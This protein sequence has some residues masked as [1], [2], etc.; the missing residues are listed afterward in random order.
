MNAHADLHFPRRD[1]EIRPASLRQRT[2]RKRD[3]ERIGALVGAARDPDDL[4][5]RQ[6]SVRGGAGGLEDEHIAG[7]AAPLRALGA[8]RR[9]DIVGRQHRARLDAFHSSS[10]DAMSKFMTSPE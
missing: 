4:I 5:E 9:G 3:A 1:L 8:R 10:S 6:H 2:G 7:D